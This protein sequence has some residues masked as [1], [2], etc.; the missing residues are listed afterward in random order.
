MATDEQGVSAEVL[1][2][3]DEIARQPF[4]ELHYWMHAMT[5]ADCRAILRALDDSQRLQW[6]RRNCL[7]VYY[8]GGLEYPVEHLPDKKE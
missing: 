2:R 4:A 1:E 6:V 5:P 7:V 8:P 3:L